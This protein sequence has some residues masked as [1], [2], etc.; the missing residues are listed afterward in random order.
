MAGSR[1][2]KPCVL[3]RWDSCGHGFSSGGSYTKGA[4]QS[5]SV[6]SATEDGVYVGGLYW[7]NRDCRAMLNFVTLPK[8][9]A[10][11]GGI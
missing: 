10:V 8:R 9:I 2:G 11:A 7:Q 5:I 6:D 3:C 1:S 4:S